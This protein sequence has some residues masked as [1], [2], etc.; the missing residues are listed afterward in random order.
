MWNKIKWYVYA[1]LAVCA[2]IIVYIVFKDDDDAMQQLNE[3]MFDK[4]IQLVREQISKTAVKSKKTQAEIEVID[5]KIQDLQ[6]KRESD[7]DKIDKASIVELKD[8]FK[9]IHS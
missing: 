8:L 7:N 4:R 6:S 5:K 9:E 1:A 3:W 2:V